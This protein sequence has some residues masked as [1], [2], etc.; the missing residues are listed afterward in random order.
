MS[1]DIRSGCKAV[2]VRPVIYKL[3]ESFSYLFELYCLTVTMSMIVCAQ[4]KTHWSENTF[5]F[6]PY[7]QSWSRASWYLFLSQ[8]IPCLGSL[9]PLGLMWFI[10][11]RCFQV[12]IYNISDERKSKKARIQ[13]EEIFD[14]DSNDVDEGKNILSR[15]YLSLVKIAFKL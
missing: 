9:I 2:D 8:L 10:S 7:F 5:L 13:Q 12:N 14:D 4:L 15:N 1:R 3:N 11:L 6:F